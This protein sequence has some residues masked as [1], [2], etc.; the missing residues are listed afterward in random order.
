MTLI[1]MLSLS[2]SKSRITLVQDGAK[3]DSKDKDGK[4][5]LDLA[6]AS[7]G[8]EA[9]WTWGKTEEQWEWRTKKRNADV[10]LLE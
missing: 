2:P 9:K 1:L 3:V 5:A 4:M 10:M 8:D 7:A 6:A